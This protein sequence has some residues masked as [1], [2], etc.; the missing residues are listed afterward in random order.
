MLTVEAGEFLIIEN[1]ALGYR[2]KFLLTNFSYYL[3]SKVPELSGCMY[4]EEMDGPPAQKAAWQT[5]RLNIY[6]GSAMNFFRSLIHDV[7]PEAGFTIFKT[8]KQGYIRQQ[9]REIIKTCR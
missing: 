7:D 4:F 1:L 3:K 6:K 9:K 5:N 8:V 2:L